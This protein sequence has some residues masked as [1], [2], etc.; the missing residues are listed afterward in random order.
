MKVDTIRSVRYRHLLGIVLTLGFAMVLALSV[1]TGPGYAAPPGL[2]E[3]VTGALLQ[4][5][6]ADPA[7]TPAPVIDHMRAEGDWA[8]GAATIPVSAADEAPTSS[9]YI[10]VRSGQQWQVGL[11]GSD[12]F[13]SLI[14]R[15]PESVVSAGEKATFTAPQARAINTGLSLPWRQGDSWYMGG[16]PHGNSG[17]SRPFNSIDFNGGDGRVLAAGAGRVYKTCVRGDSAEVKVVHNNGYTTTYYHMTNLITAPNG[18]EIAEGTYLG[19]IGTRLPCG[20][21]ASGPHVHL[22]LWNTNG[23]AVAVN[24]KTLGGWTFYE[25]ASAYRGYAERNGVRVNVGGRLTNYGSDTAPAKG[26]VRPHPDPNG[27]VNLY[28]GPGLKFSITGTARNGDVV[29]ITCTARGDVV[30]GKW[31]N[32]DLWNKLDSG[33]WISDGF[34]DTGSNDPVA[35]TCADPRT[36]TSVPSGGDSAGSGARSGTGG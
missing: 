12:E 5:K 33:K 16:G 10:A 30:A 32:T 15:A 13:R 7:R 25:G 6:Q 17:N 28:S 36:A 22:A 4:K 26:T 31:G 27:T 11:E 9:F 21:S 19:R 8:F 2:D 23:G 24:G 14:Q 20:G 18:T 3:A 35:P 29:R 1:A 34:V